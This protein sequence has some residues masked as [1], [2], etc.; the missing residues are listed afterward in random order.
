[1]NRREMLTHIASAVMAPLSV[2]QPKHWMDTL[3]S[4]EIE[5]LCAEAGVWDQIKH[6]RNRQ[7]RDSRRR[8]QQ[9]RRAGNVVLWRGRLTEGLPGLVWRDVVSSRRDVRVATVTAPFALM[10]YAIP[11]GARVLVDSRVRDAIIGA[12]AEIIETP[13]GI[14]VHV[15]PTPE[16][17]KAGATLADQWPTQAGL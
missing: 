8:R 6:A 15:W 11:L 10:S 4:H 16:I 3:S 2:P 14:R 12:R 1:M 13:H 9:E 7:W 5:A 17:I